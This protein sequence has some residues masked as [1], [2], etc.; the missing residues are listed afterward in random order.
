M[1]INSELERWDWMTKISR[2]FGYTVRSCFMKQN[3]RT[4]WSMPVILIFPVAIVNLMTKKFSN[5]KKY[6]V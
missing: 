2:E 5:E 3:K 6:F 1:S 4:W